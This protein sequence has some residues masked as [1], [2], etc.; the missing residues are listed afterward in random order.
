MALSG[1]FG[2]TFRTGYRLQVDWSASQDIAN[3]TSTITA[4]LYLIS[5]GASYTISSSATKDGSQTIDGGSNS[6]SG[7]GLASL[8][9][10]QKK[11][12]NTYSRT[13]SHNADGTKSLSMSA[14]FDIEVTLGGT[15]Y[16]RVSCDSG[17]I[18]LDTIPRASSLTSGRD[19]TAGTQNLAVSISRASTSFTH[20][21]EVRVQKPDGT[22]VYIG[23]R[24]GIGTSTTFTFSLAEN[25]SIYQAISQYENRPS[26]IRL[27]TWNGGT[28]IGYKD[29]YG[30]VY[31][32]G[33][34]KIS[35][36]NFNIGDSIPATI[37]G[38]QNYSGFQYTGI[39]KVA[40]TTIKTFTFSPSTPNPTLTFTSAEITQ[41]YNLTPNSNSVSGQVTVT[42]KYNGVDI[43]DGLPAP[44]YD[45]NFNFTAYVTNSNPT[46]ADTSISYKDVNTTTTGI[47]SNDQYIIQNQSSVTAYVNTAATMK[48]GATFSKYVVT[49]NGKQ[50]TI[51]TTT[52]N[53]NIGTINATT[54]Q[55]LT[56]TVYDSRGNST[57]VTKTVIV[58]PHSEPALSISLE[59]A[60]KFE[61]S[62]TLKVSGS[63]SLL[64]VAGT[65]KNAILSLKYRYKEK[66]ASTYGADQTI[67]FT[68]NNG[69]FTGANIVLTLDNTKSWDFEVVVQDQI[70]TN[71]D[72]ASVGTGQPILFIDSTKKSV[73]VMRFPSGSSSFEVQGTI[74]SYTGTITS[75]NP[76]N[77]SASVSLSWKDN[78]ARIRYGGSGD[79]AAGG[80]QIQG[81]SDIVKFS[82]D[83]DGNGK[84]GGNV[85]VTGAGSRFQADGQY[86]STNTSGGAIRIEGYNNLLY[87][88]TGNTNND[89]NAWIQSRHLD[90]NFATAMGTL[91]LQPLGGD[92]KIGSNQVV[93]DPKKQINTGLEIGSTAL[94]SAAYSFIDF[95][96]S[97][98][99]NDYDAR[100]I[101]YGGSNGANGMGQMT[102]YAGT[103]DFQNGTV[104][105][106]LRHR[107]NYFDLGSYSSSYGSGNARIWFDANG[108]TLHFWNQNNGLT[109]LR[110]ASFST[111]SK[112]EYKTNI[113]PDQSSALSKVKATTIYDYHMKEDLE[114][115]V[116]KEN[117]EWEFTGQY[118]DPTTVKK[119]KGLILEEAPVELIYNDEGIDLYAMISM[120][121]KAVQEL[122]D[123]VDQ[124]TQFLDQKKMDKPTT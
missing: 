51:S 8:S 5:L 83:N 71:T 105:G 42:S 22:W 121:W 41:M 108:N 97:V 34:A 115:W 60:N 58:V 54:N 86:S 73:G 63:F 48:N 43:N 74:T 50:G 68:T 12:I 10:N 47:T 11:L 59:R 75:L 13:V 103:F 36:S 70:V 4:N 9:G 64:N 44:T 1:S 102:L 25:T 96:S 117:G 100:I 110:A 76:D 55:T 78:I 52:G 106:R 29:Y 80:F 53:V 112:R 49:I 95:H 2:N 26:W 84:F 111:T 120:V 3:N 94:T 98:Y 107:D 62:T 118:K 30:T 16:G 24:D 33:I 116:E 18:T 20:S 119:R 46:F 6:F 92:L 65:N 37:T 56:I 27:I 45:P 123:K 31:G 81:T 82:V 122:S 17:T 72:H 35:F 89:R 38:M 79:G 15:Y 69:T 90:S 67:A 23:A 99:N 32:A 19:W 39:F 114:I 124:R 66:G 91:S 61:A 88:G 87:M 85:Y 101:S 14:W 28:M 40:G 77:V 21:V 7:A 93:I 113:V 104:W 57:S 109:N